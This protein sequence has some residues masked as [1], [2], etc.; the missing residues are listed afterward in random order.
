[1]RYV[2]P[3]TLLLLLA[4]AACGRNGEDENNSTTETTPAPPVLGE[5]PVMVYGV[6]EDEGNQTTISEYP[7]EEEDLGNGGSETDMEFCCEVTFAIA[8]PDGMED[9]VSVRLVG[10]S[11]PLNEG[12]EMTFADGVWSVDS[13]VVPEYNGTYVYIFTREVE[14]EFIE[15]VHYN[16]YAPR[17]GQDEFAENL[18]TSADTCEESMVEQHAITSGDD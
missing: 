10:D 15:E 4:L 11:Y 7:Y 1:M 2:K 16:P 9:E 6:S 13:C 12:I 17:T 3:V 8:D 18:W 5:R 14:G